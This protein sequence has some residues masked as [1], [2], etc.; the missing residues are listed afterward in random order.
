MWEAGC[1]VCRC[2]GVLWLRICCCLL[3]W[4]AVNVRVKLHQDV[5]W[6]PRIILCLEAAGRKSQ[7]QYSIKLP[8]NNLCSIIYTEVFPRQMSV[9]RFPNVRVRLVTAP[10]G[11]MDLTGTSLTLSLLHFSHNCQL[12]MSSLYYRVLYMKLK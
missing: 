9:R 2:L 1:H 4:M 6:S 11:F 12:E 10:S 3:A 5:D 8:R 7:E